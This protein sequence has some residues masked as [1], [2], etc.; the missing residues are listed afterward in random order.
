MTAYGIDGGESD[1][2]T[3]ENLSV[4]LVNFD[5]FEFVIETCLHKYV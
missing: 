1:Y 4:N 3:K 5:V 2:V